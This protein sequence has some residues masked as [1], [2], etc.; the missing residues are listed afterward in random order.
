MESKGRALDKD[1]IG[2]LGEDLAARFLR[3]REGM[4]VL[5][6][7]FRAKKGGEVDIVCR[8]REVLVFVEVKTR[9][10]LAFGRPVE[11]VTPAKQELI[12]KGALEWLRLLDFPKINFRFDVVEL[13]LENGQPA[14]IER[15]PNAFTMPPSYFYPGG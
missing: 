13:I 8:D 6:R 3:R 5:Y 11:A 10:S 7:N 12:T 1:E 4:K 14:K 15:V 9:T 2:R